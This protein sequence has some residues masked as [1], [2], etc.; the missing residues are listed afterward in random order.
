MAC[1][2]DSITSGSGASHKL[3]TSYPVILEI[4][5]NENSQD[6][7][8]DVYKCVNFGVGGKTA[9][10]NGVGDNHE[11]MSYWDTTAYKTSLI[12]NPDIVIIGLGS[13]DA[14]EQNW[15]ENLFISDYTEL[16]A[17]FRRLKSV[18]EIYI[19]IP[20]PLYRPF[21]RMR[22]DVINYKLGEVIRKIAAKNNVKVINLFQR[23]GGIKFSKPYLFFTPRKPLKW[24]NDGCHP[25]DH[26]YRVIARSVYEAI[27][28]YD[29]NIDPKI[30]VGEV[31]NDDVDEALKREVSAMYEKDIL[32]KGYT[33]TR[34]TEDKRF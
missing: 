7:S 21:A 20:P 9:M 26:G 16:I 29:R 15:N 6:N 3:K 23:M 13:N 27:L 32:D 30:D 34:A 22:S 11:P 28:R 12:S 31:D 14:K 17:S 33:M 4:L 10:K 2:G 24:P 5:L 8:N 19:L 1:V 25:N 18:K